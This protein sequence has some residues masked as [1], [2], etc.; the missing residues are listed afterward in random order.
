MSMNQKKRDLPPTTS[1]PSLEQIPPERCTCHSLSPVHKKI[2]NAKLEAEK[3]EI[4]PTSSILHTR[5]SNTL[6]TLF[7]RSTPLSIFLLHISQWDRIHSTQQLTLPQRQHYHVSSDLMEQVIVNVRRVMRADD[8]IFLQE[9]AGAAIVFPNVD[10]QGAYIILERIYHSVC[11]LQAETLLPPLTLNTTIL[12]GMSSY[13][14]PASSLEQLLYFT[15]LAARCFTLRPAIT[16]QL[17]HTSTS[18]IQE[19]AS[20]DE[21]SQHAKGQAGFP[22]MDLPSII[23]PRLQQ[24]IPHSLATELR[25]VP[26]GRNHHCLTVAMAEPTNYEHVQRLHSA[27]GLT[28]FPVSCDL[29]ELSTLLTKNW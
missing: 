10:Q 20:K 24:L 7:P 13:P 9:Q 11:L 14:E 21:H 23:P 26:V 6:Q 3:E 27:T 15:S 28:I 2:V 19:T 17:W 18:P 16:T 12:M 29:E 25:C 4:V 22:F 1:I 5:L 8:Q